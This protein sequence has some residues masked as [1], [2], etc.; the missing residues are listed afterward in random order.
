MVYAKWLPRRRPFFRP[1]FARGERTGHHQQYWSRVRWILR[2][3]LN[4]I[5]ILTF[6][7]T[8]HRLIAQRIIFNSIL[9]AIRTQRLKSNRDQDAQR[10]SCHV[11]LARRPIVE[12]RVRVGRSKQLCDVRSDALA[13]SKKLPSQ[14]EELHWQEGPRAIRQSLVNIFYLLF[15]SDDDND[16][17]SWPTSSTDFIFLSIEQ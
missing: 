9:N 8:P 5:F 1:F 3:N 12:S 13:R 16:A 14:A 7:F 4:F 17:S 6:L 2:L 11:Q 10:S 15:G